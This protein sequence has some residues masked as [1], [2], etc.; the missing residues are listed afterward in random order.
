MV[1]V[2]LKAPAT[3][4]LADVAQQAGPPARGDGDVANSRA[5]IHCS[6]YGTEG[7]RFES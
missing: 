4:E 3:S 6:A 1:S 5:A 2:H 7:L